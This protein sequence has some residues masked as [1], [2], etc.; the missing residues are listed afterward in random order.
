[1]YLKKAWQLHNSQLQ[2]NRI[3]CESSDFV[4]IGFKVRELR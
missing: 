1:M 4:Y 2:T 3:I